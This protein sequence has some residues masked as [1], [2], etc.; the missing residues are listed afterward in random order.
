M[1]DPTGATFDPKT[2]GTFN[3]T[4]NHKTARYDC[5]TQ[6]YK[7][8]E[9]KCGHL[10]WQAPGKCVETA[11]TASKHDSDGRK[12]D[13]VNANK[14]FASVTVAACGLVVPRTGTGTPCTW[15]AAPVAAEQYNVKSFTFHSPSEHSV[16]GNKY[17]MEMQIEFCTGDCEVDKDTSY[18]A[19]D[20]P[21]DTAKFAMYSVFFEAG[22]ANTD[23]ATAVDTMFE[24][25]KRDCP[26]NRDKF[27]YQLSKDDDG[28]G[29]NDE[30][31]SHC[32]I[33]AGLLNKN[34]QNLPL[35]SVMV[36]SK[37]LK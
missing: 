29:S 15:I 26:Q 21:S 34:M 37:V 27:G 4:Q 18:F 30:A 12:T 1:P 10:M 8:N 22:D 36:Y 9:G 11:P 23:A 3:P 6:G 2:D 7:A 32:R 19:S 5:G 24:Y 16:N 28:D 31:V 20:D 25:K 33:L 13:P 17:A 35:I 14:C